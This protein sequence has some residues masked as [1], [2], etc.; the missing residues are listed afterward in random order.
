MSFREAKRRGNSCPIRHHCRALLPITDYDPSPILVITE[1]IYYDGLICQYLK[2]I[3]T[4][5]ST[6]GGLW[7]ILPRKNRVLSRSLGTDAV[8]GM[9]GFPRTFVRQSGP[10]CA[11]NA[12]ALIGISRTSSVE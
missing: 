9:N 5:K 7:E 1:G 11:L 2:N 6:R 12:K 10:E 8:V 4:G 3:L